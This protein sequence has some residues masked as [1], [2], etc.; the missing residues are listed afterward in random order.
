[1]GTTVLI[2]EDFTIDVIED[3]EESDFSLQNH[4]IKTEPEWCVE[5]GSDTAGIDGYG[6]KQ[7]FKIDIEENYLSNDEFVDVLQVKTEIT[8][9]IGNDFVVEENLSDVKPQLSSDND[10]NLS[11]EEQMVPSQDKLVL[12]EESNRSLRV[13]SDTKSCTDAVPKENR[14]NSH[15]DVV[16]ARKTQGGPLDR[17]KCSITTKRNQQTR[18]PYQHRDKNVPP[19]RFRKKRRPLNL[20]Y[21]YQRPNRTGAPTPSFRTSTRFRNRPPV[22]RFHN[23]RT[24]SNEALGRNQSRDLFN[25]EAICR[26]HDRWQL[27]PWQGGGEACRPQVWASEIQTRAFSVLQI[28]TILQTVAQLSDNLCKQHCTNNVTWEMS[29]LNIR[30]TR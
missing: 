11:Q 12:K 13:E 3:E 16:P 1:M 5:D 26:G 27:S 17:R 15:K 9:D 23:F 28:C 2:D 8:D 18:V 19:F 21:P 20:W 4:Q 22:W 7:E 30:M 24:H 6:I 25:G 10:G 29:Q 14:D